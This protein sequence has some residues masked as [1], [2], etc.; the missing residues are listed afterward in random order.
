MIGAKKP[1]SEAEEAGNA[2]G[3]VAEQG[4][5]LAAEA[6]HQSD[7]ADH[8]DDGEQRGDEERD[9][10][11]FALQRLEDL[12]DQLLVVIGG[13]HDVAVVLG[14]G[15]RVCR[16]IPVDRRISLERRVPVEWRIPVE[17]VERRIPAGRGDARPALAAFAR[18]LGSG[19]DRS[20]DRLR[21]VG[22]AH[23]ERVLDRR[24]RNL[25]W[26][27]ALLRVD[28]HVGPPHKLRHSRGPGLRFDRAHAPM[29]DVQPAKSRWNPPVT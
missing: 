16:R 3:E 29:R 26:V 7:R 2:R 20:C 6:D 13:V 8:P 25:G 22:V 24:K 9:A 10:L 28:R 19:R 5:Q 21:R 1:P 18:S 17:P 12:A 27:F 11:R 23:I 4:A 15:Q 14:R